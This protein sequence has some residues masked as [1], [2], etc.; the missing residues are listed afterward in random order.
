MLLL[1]GRRRKLMADPKLLGR[2]GEKCSERFLKNKG[3]TTIARN[4]SCKGGEVD[5]VM[6]SNDG[7]VIFVEVKSRRDEDFAQAQE[8]VN[9]AKRTKLVR[10]AR[11]FLQTYNV[12]DKPLRF[13]VIAVVLGRKGPVRIRHYENVFTP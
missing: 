2:W 5:L 10:T 6:A 12:N 7:A 11:F 9:P 3:L 4:F 13:D 1:P 8:A